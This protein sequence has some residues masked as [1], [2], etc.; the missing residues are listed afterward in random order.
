MS[1][2]T[3]ATAF[4][5]PFDLK[6][7][8]NWYRTK[9]DRDVLAELM[10][11]SNFRGW[12]QTVLHLGL[13]FCTAGLAYYV[14]TLI[15]TG[16]WFWTLP[17]LVLCLFIHGTIGPFMGLIA[18]HELQH[19]TVFKTRWPNYLF[20]QVYSF[21]SWSDYIWYQESHAL[22]H[23]STCHFDLDG[24]VRL[25]IRFSLRRWRVWLGLLAWNP[26]NT[27]SRIKLV[28]NHANGRVSGDWYQH[29]LPASNQRL[30]ERHQNWARILLVGHAILGIGFIAS[31]HWFLLVVFTFGTFYCGWLGFLCGLP[32][33]YGMNS[34]IPDFRANTRTFTC[35]WLPAFYYW[36]M[37][38]HLEHHMY[39][40]VPFY[41]LPKL[42]RAL[43][44]DLPA[45]PHGLRATWKE[46]L[47]L[48]KQFISD[49]NFSYMPIMPNPIGKQSKASSATEAI[50]S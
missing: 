31:G 50:E 6:T 42:R 14:F 48:R 43:A 4:E 36:N 13:F 30:R 49:P 15:N 17:L 29:V 28:W 1:E 2:T 3:A 27:W 21:I 40:S 25:P 9:I 7:K 22:H 24:E 35:S 10:K 5:S 26:R 41:N 34:D 18:V 20:E 37:Q 32:Q 16:N 11:R 19:R 33:H 23:R 47:S 39:P 12:L 46:M 8:I 44:H 38:Y 45:A